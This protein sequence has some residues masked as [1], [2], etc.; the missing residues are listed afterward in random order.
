[1]QALAE[2]TKLQE[3]LQAEAL[4]K[5]D[6]EEVRDQLQARRDL[7]EEEV[8]SLTH[9]LEE[10][11]EKVKQLSDEGKQLKVRIPL[12]LLSFACTVSKKDKI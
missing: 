6:L 7:L 12:Q 10:T 2:R 8:K 9:Q 3:Q 1:M 4:E 11:D 5:V